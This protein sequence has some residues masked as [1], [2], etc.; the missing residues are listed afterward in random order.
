MGKSAKR[1]FDLRENPEFMELRVKAMHT[2]PAKKEKIYRQMKSSYVIEETQEYINFDGVTVII[3]SKVTF[4]MDG[5]MFTYSILGNSEGNFEN[6][7]MSCDAPLAEALLGKRI[8]DTIVFNSAII[9]VI[10]VERI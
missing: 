3:G 9:R 10:K 8:G 6:D 7:I 2:L 5:M 4:D 1:D